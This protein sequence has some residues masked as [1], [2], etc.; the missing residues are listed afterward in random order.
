ML[1]HYFLQCELQMIAKNKDHMNKL[2]ETAKALMDK[3]ED[4]RLEESMQQ[5]LSDYNKL[6][7]HTHDIL[8]KHKEGKQTSKVS[9]SQ[10]WGIFSNVI[11][12]FFVFCFVNME[13]NGQTVIVMCYHQGSAKLSSHN[14][15]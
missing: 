1:S 10:I 14:K 2:L 13:F 15:Y 9:W 8:L 11:L 7:K 3:P 12:F 4:T 5:K 6:L